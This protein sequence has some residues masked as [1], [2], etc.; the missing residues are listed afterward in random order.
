MV[1]CLFTRCPTLAQNHQKEKPFY[2]LFF[3]LISFLT[4]IPLHRNPKTSYVNAA[5][6]HCFFYFIPYDGM[7]RYKQF[8][9]NHYVIV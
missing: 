6:H 4:K 5:L 9:G 2:E 8:I 7:K 1:Y 3:R